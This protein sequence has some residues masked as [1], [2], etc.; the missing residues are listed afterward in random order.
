MNS[1]V[2]SLPFSSTP[3]AGCDDN[4]GTKLFK[5]LPTL[6][7]FYTSIIFDIIVRSTNC[8]SDVQDETIFA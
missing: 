8:S 4:S 7:K 3:I 5:L 2:S 6:S 1:S